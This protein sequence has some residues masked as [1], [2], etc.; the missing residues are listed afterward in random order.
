MHIFSKSSLC[1]RLSRSN[2]MGRKG[3]GA[4]EERRGTDE[5]SVAEIYRPCC[6]VPLSPTVLPQSSPPRGLLGCRHVMEKR[7]AAG[8]DEVERELREERGEEK[9]RSH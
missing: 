7:G 8:G 2:T 3:P 1:T 4:L 6:L 5:A 9:E